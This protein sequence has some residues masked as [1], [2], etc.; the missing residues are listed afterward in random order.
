M[1]VLL[2]LHSMQWLA[3]CHTKWPRGSG[4]KLELKYFLK[5]SLNNFAQCSSSS[6]PMPVS[7][8]CMSGISAHHFRNC[9]SFDELWIFRVGPAAFTIQTGRKIL[10]PRVPTTMQ[11]CSFF[12][13]P[14]SE[15]CFSTPAFSS[16]ILLYKLVQVFDTLK[17][18]VRC[19]GTRDTLKKV[20]CLIRSYALFLL[21]CHSHM[22]L[23]IQ[24]S[25]PAWSSTYR[26][27]FSTC[28]RFHGKD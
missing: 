10:N 2:S 20:I 18:P 22:N 13:N 3:Q 12:S 25:W 4:H 23:N 14:F 1:I 15:F 7:P 11:A 5:F 16:T 8:S 24:N 9:R 28:N 27:Q 21:L 17:I 6:L 26:W 19:F